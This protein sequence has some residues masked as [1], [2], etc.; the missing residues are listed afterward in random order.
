M[1]LRQTAHE[2]LDA[3]LTGGTTQTQ[4]GGL[5]LTADINEVGTV[6][7]VDDTVVL[8]TATP[9]RRITVINNGANRLRVFPASGDNLGAGADT[10]LA[11]GVAA[12]ERITFVAYDTTNWEPTP[13]PAAVTLGLT[14][15][16]SQLTEAGTTSGTAV[17]LLTVANLSIAVGDVI[18]VVASLRKSSGNATVARVGLMLNATQ[19]RQPDTWSSA[20]NQ[21]ESAPWKAYFIYGRANYLRAGVANLRTVLTGIDSEVFNFTADMP[22]ATGTDVILRANSN[23]VAITMSADDMHVHSKAIV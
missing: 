21:A 16:G 9:G 8:P 1:T 5:A 13:T 14:L 4:A 10:A 11:A 3:G 6:A 2:T 15:L 23:N 17:S 20:T 19:V 18:E 12:G 22:T 7:N